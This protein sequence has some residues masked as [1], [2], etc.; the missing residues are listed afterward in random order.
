MTQNKPRSAVE[1]MVH[2]RY[3]DE[4]KLLDR[5]MQDIQQ[6][7]KAKLPW[8]N[9][10]FGK[11]YKLVSHESTGNKF[12]YPA[13]YV[14]NGEYASLMPNDQY[15]NFSWFDIYDP[16]TVEETIQGAPTHRVKGALVFWY[17]LDSIYADNTFIYTEEVKDEILKV[18]TTPGL[19]KSRGK[20]NI[21]QI[22][23]KFEAIYKGYSIEKI[24]NDKLYK[25][26]NIQSIDKQYFMHPYAGIRIEFELRLK[27]VC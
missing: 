16:I 22:Y 4:P 15:G 8:L 26:Q 6:A 19:L 24:Y 13:A 23:E 18:L 17:N 7:L 1:K 25:G 14:G 10:A 27:E 2:I 20:L 12:V 21:N 9:C 5:A 3:K 11:A